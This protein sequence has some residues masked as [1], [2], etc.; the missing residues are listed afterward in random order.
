MSEELKALVCDRAGE[1]RNTLTATRRDIVELQRAL[2]ELEVL[3]RKT[4][5]DFDDIVVEML[6]GKEASR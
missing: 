1:L 4:A 6:H 2:A 3:V 5:N